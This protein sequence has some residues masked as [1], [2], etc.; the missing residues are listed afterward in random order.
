VVKKAKE[1]GAALTNIMPLIPAPGSAFE[2]YPQTTQ[3]DVN[4]MREQ[5]EEYLPQMRH[6]QQCRA[7]AIGLLT[8]DRSAEF[9]NT[10][11]CS[12]KSCSGDAGKLPTFRVAVTSRGGKMVDQHFGHASMF[13]IY[14]TDGVKEK[15]VE[16]RSVERYCTGSDQCGD[17]EDRK[18]AIIAQ[19]QDC[20]AVVSMRIGYYAKQRLQMHKVLAVESCASI[21]EGLELA[22]EQLEIKKAG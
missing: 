21:S 10:G 20:D 19:L 15:L 6:C 7:D 4:T 9:R 2:H 11:N 13:L 1:L 22:I 5:C 12:G 18:N 16:L 8:E 17:E 3:K 14:E